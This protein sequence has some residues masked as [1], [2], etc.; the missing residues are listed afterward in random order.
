MPTGFD[1]KVIATISEWV[2]VA[3]LLF[4]IVDYRMVSV[5]IVMVFSGKTETVLSIDSGLR[6]KLDR[7]HYDIPISLLLSIML[8]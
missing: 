5:S 6:K 8:L 1:I 4:G 7:F 2:D 3:N